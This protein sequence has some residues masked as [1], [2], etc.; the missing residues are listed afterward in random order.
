MS[1][2]DKICD[3]QNLYRAHLKSRR[4]KQN[5][6]EVINF[7][8]NLAYNLAALSQELQ[9][10][11]YIS[12][13]Y[14]KFTV[15]DPKERIIHALHYKDRVVQHCICDEVLGPLLDKKL[16]YDNA[17]CR[18]GKGTHFALKRLRRFLAEYYKEYGAEGYFLKFDIR[19]YFDNI[20]HEVLKVLLE[21]SVQDTRVYDLLCNIIGGYSTSEGKGLPLGNQT[22]QWFAIY[23]LNGLDR[24]AKEILGFK[25]YSRYMDD[26]V[27]LWHDKQE[28]KEKLGLLSRYVTSELKLEFNEKTQISP[29]RNGIDYLG[30]H[31]Y[32]TE[33]GKILQ[34]LRNVTKHRYKRKLKNMSELFEKNLMNFE[35]I[36]QVINSYKGHLAYGDTYKLQ[37]KFLNDFVLCKKSY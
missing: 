33:N 7:E 22:S 32:L 36:G 13:E 31:F 2:Y 12:G 10:G 20:D 21:R 19:K 8:M 35:E 16:I 3:F 27:M 25:Y 23:Y 15:Y 11:L 30:W 18:K 26:A 9:E 24:Y 29:I 37:S 14:Y 6:S 17:A 4:S 5:N 28:L 34:K 1:D